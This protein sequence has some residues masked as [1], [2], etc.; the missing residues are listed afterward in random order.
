MTANAG[1]RG[2]VPADDFRWQAFFQQTS[3]ALF[4]LDRQ[5]RLRFVNGAWETLAGLPFV[6]ARLLACRRL[7][8]ATTED[9]REEILA[10][11]L[12]PPSEVLEGATARVRRLL[13]ASREAPVAAQC[14]WDVEFFPLRDAKGVRGILGRVTPAG[15]VESVALLP[16]PEKVAGLRE[17]S[18]GKYS[19]DQI[20]VG[21]PAMRRL[22]EQVRLASQVSVPA[23]LVSEAGAGKQWLARVIH[24]QGTN[25]ERGF[26]ALDCARLPVEALLDILL[27]ERGDNQRGQLATFYLKDP[28]SLPREIQLRLVERIGNRTGPRVLA[29]CA[30]PAADVR[31]GRMLDDLHA[32]LGTLV[33]EVPPLRERPADLPHLVERLLQRVPKK[34]S[35]GGWRL[36]P[37]AWN[38]LQR[39]TWPGNLRELADAL[40]QA[41]RY[42]SDEGIDA[43]DLPAV[44]R[45]AVDGPASLPERSLP[46]DTILEQVE[47]RLLELALQRTGG[48]R[49]RAAE[50]L[51]IW[52]PRLNRR[53]Q[54]LGLAVASPDIEI[55]EPEP[56]EPGS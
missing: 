24:Y 42:G 22:V 30:A 29:G 25:R 23:L 31:A 27:G 56:T 21:S 19:L 12:C 7:A 13:P 47:R 32:A 14:W 33:I 51:G 5:R 2:P 16:V 41:S 38:L 18:V 49:S 9:S 37:G 15:V 55:D 4:L 17:R 52:R 48:N 3:D 36:T 28:A 35:T 8:P 20:P 45:T 54:A 34:D 10:H 6:Q 26:A 43:A 44:V 46:L 40:A 11:A 53:L 39:Y 1:A 50:L